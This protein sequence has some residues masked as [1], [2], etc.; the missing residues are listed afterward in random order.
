MLKL[1][2]TERLKVSNFVFWW[3][4]CRGRVITDFYRPSVILI[5]CRPLNHSEYTRSKIWRTVDIDTEMYLAILQLF[6]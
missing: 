4:Y 2:R 6:D 3:P 1:L 5:F